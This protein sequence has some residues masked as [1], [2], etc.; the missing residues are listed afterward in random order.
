MALEI[1]CFKNQ[2]LFSIKYDTSS[3]IIFWCGCRVKSGCVWCGQGEVKS[4]CPQSSP[5]VVVIQKCR[6]Q[7][8]MSDKV[9]LTS[10][11]NIQKS[12]LK[13]KNDGLILIGS[14]T[15]KR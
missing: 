3:T 12:G 5:G 13:I 1:K 14:C 6:G 15:G 2:Y 7:K 4:H 9:I 8:V 10:E 11:K